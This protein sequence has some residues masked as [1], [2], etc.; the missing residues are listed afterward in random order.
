MQF[1]IRTRHKRFP[2][3]QKMMNL[4]PSVI[5]RRGYDRKVQFRRYDL[6]KS[7]SG[8]RTQ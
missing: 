8:Y 3:A 5:G 4:K 7:E 6:L 2:R 1:S